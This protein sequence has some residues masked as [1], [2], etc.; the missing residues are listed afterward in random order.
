MT[1]LAVGL[2]V[3][4]IACSIIVCSVF[5]MASLQPAHAKNFR[6]IVSR[7]CMTGLRGP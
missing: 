6:A 3:L 5:A 2:G 4:G 7:S 1:D